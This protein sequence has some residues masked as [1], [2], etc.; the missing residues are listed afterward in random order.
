[1][2]RSIINKILNEI[3]TQTHSV[4]L[5][6]FKGYGFG[7]PWAPRKRLGYGVLNPGEE[8][9]KP[10]VHKPVKISRAFKKEDL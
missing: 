7:H 4:N 1:M 3:E 9:E 10:V 6:T 8:E 2:M 5:K